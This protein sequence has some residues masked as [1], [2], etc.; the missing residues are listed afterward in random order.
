M[1]GEAAMT[2]TL[3]MNPALRNVVSVMM[4]ALLW[5]G[6]C[7]LRTAEP[8][9]A[10]QLVKLDDGEFEKRL[11]AVLGQLSRTQ[12][13][14]LADLW[15][16][17]DRL[18]RDRLQMPESFSAS[19]ARHVARSLRCGY[20]AQMICRHGGADDFKRLLKLA[21]QLPAD[22]W[23]RR[24]ILQALIDF[25]IKDEVD[26]LLKANGRIK[27]NLPG[28]TGRLP[29]GA[30]P[31][32]SEAA[33]LY[34]AVKAIR[35]ITSP[36]ARTNGWI[37]VEA[38]WGL[39]CDVLTDLLYRRGTE[40]SQ[41]ISQFEWG[42]WC[43]T[44]SD[45]LYGPKNRALFLALLRERRFDQALNALM[46]P[47]DRQFLTLSFL[48][49]DSRWKEGFIELCGI[50]WEM[51]YAGSIPSQNAFQLSDEIRVLA[52]HGSERGARLLLQL[53]KQASVSDRD[54]YLRAVAALVEPN[55]PR[56][57]T[58]ANGTITVLLR[59]GDYTRVAKPIPPDLQRELLQILQQKLQPG[60]TARVAET[61]CR[62]LSSLGGANSKDALRAAL[63]HPNPRVRE[64]AAN[65]LRDLGESALIP[66]RASLTPVRFRLL[67]NGQPLTGT[68]LEFSL[69]KAG[70]GSFGSSGQTDENGVISVPRDDFEDRTSP[71]KNITFATLRLKALDQACF[72][73]PLVPPDDLTAVT[74]LKIDLQPLTISLGGEFA[75]DF[76]AAEQVHVTCH[77]ERPVSDGIYVDAIAG[78]TVTPFASK[79]IFS[80][81]QPGRYRVQLRIPG[82]ALWKSD[83]ELPGQS[84]VNA[85]L[86]RGADVRYRIV[87]PGSETHDPRIPF[88]LIHEGKPLPTYLYY[89][90]LTNLV[91]SL[92]MGQYRFRVRSTSEER[93]LWRSPNEIVP[94]VRGHLG[95]E[96]PFIITETSPKLIDLGT[97]RL[98]S[99]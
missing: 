43:G 14:P 82:A 68:S 86:K 51:L 98:R 93:N 31:D 89:S 90:G 27:I 79:I 56:T 22:S 95:A 42:S 5:S 7:N 70:S 38:N 26:S 91:C 99:E 88:E 37:G 11:I 67:T 55:P 52:S 40:T 77:P 57:H 28:F 74:D 8:I 83:I 20:V 92:P 34:N 17:M 71:V 13:V 54:E 72:R 84:V 94:K 59:F 65:A 63:N 33:R 18:E 19:D 58:N 62:L 97:I 24:R 12:P 50:D 48:K 30:Q 66:P 75:P 23:E 21:D 47:S 45:Q 61:V 76:L 4:L 46:L 35:P 25:A 49:D 2:R 41:K 44:G 16:I 9:T 6:L 87:P 96:V 29:D 69:Q 73:V 3:A 39:F 81:L 64:L 15:L 78:G 80:A 60:V 53:G 1:I 32:L 10:A 85:R 36:A